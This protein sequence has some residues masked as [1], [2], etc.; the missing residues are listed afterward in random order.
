MESKSIKPKITWFI[1]ARGWKRFLHPLHHQHWNP[2]YS[3]SSVWIR[4]Y[5]IAPYLRQ[6][7]HVIECNKINPPPDVAIF[8]RR[9][10]VEDLLL[11]ERLKACGV[12][13]IVDV[14]VNY[15]THQEK[16]EN[17][18]FLK[19]IRLADQVWTV[20]PFLQDVA[21]RYHPDVHFVAESVDPKHFQ[22]ETNQN[23]MASTPLTLGWSGIASKAVC[24]EPLAP[25]L[26]PLIEQKKLRVRIIT[27]SLPRLSFPFE[28]HRWRHSRLPMDIEGCDLCIAPR[29][30]NNDYEKGHSLF[31][32]G[33]FMAMNVPALASPVPS[34][35]LLL[36][37]GQAGAICRSL[38]QW[39]HHLMQFLKKSD[40]R[41][42]WQ[43]N[44][45]QKMAPFMTP[46][47]TEQIDGLLK[48]LIKN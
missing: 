32:I 31:K 44:A 20:S 29:D 34:Y 24:L 5:Q 17:S 33:V 43:K 36:G 45:S 23:E 46:S 8:L 14:I 2:E 27:N 25:I 37:D 19:L 16:T 40:L 4:S 39:E 30:I 12:K 13:I 9:Y 48:K 18:S 21:S 47:V 7:G 22:R 3:L 41:I 35:Y 42:Q 6:K 1:P 10:D 11:A 28:F 15:F 38:S 26:G